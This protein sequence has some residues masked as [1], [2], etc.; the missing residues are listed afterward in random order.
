MYIPNNYI[1]VSN[2]YGAAIRL[3]IKI[4]DSSWMYAKQHKQTLEK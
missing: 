2:Y 1:C 3:V 4:Q